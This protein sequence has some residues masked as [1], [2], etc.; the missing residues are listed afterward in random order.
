MFGISYLWHGVALRDVQDL[1]VSLETYLLV[2]G[3][4]Y[5]VLGFLV[6]MFIHHAIQREWIS[7]KHLFPFKCMVFGGLVG[8]GVFVV[9]ILTGITFAEHGALH[10]VVDLV[11]QVLEQGIGGLMACAGIMYDM[12]RTFMEAERAG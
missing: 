8:V 3:G 7:M 1:K 11:W 6:T 10:L 5:L 9:L 2:S 4:I 12:H